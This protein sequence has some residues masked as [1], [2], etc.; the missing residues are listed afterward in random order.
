MMMGF[1]RRVHTS[2][3]DYVPPEVMM[4]F[5]SSSMKAALGRARTSYHDGFGVNQIRARA[6]EM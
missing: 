4:Q 1:G 6:L 2:S 5:G 3:M